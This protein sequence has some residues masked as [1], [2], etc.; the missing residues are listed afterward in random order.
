MPHSSRRSKDP[1]H[2]LRI[3]SAAILQGGIAATISFVIAWLI[4]RV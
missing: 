1:V 2:A 4:Q 3:D